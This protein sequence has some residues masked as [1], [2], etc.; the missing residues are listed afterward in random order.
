ML[1]NTERIRL[2][3]LQTTYVKEVLLREGM[4]AVLEAVA[5]VSYQE[6]TKIC[7]EIQADSDIRAKK[8]ALAIAEKRKIKFSQYKKKCKFHFQLLV[9]TTCHLLKALVS[10]HL[11]LIGVI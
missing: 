9:L 10:V 5:G 8:I 11:L 3:S 1:V 2:Y 7:S 6:A 4:V